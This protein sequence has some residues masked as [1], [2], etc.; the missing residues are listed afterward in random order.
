MYAMRFRR[1]ASVAVL[2]AATLISIPS[3]AIAGNPVM[4]NQY[5]ATIVGDGS[6]TP[7][8]GTSGDDVIVGSANNDVINGNGG[9]DIICG[10]GGRDTI[11]GG[12]GNDQIWGQGGHDQLRGG[13][14]ND[15][16]RGGNGNDKMRGKAG[17]N[18]TTWGGLGSDVC[19]AER[20]GNCELDHRWGHD[21]AEWAD[22]IDEYFGDIGESENALIIVECES[23]GEPFAVGGTGDNYYGLFQHD[24]NDWDRRAENAGFPDGSP[25]NPEVNV[26]AA[27]WYSDA[28]VEWKNDPS[29]RWEA[30]SC[31]REL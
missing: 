23:R 20:E 3:P 17:P 11:D 13:K 1:A 29:T 30:W 26:A 8:E 14:G 7:L 31:S 21:T 18:D 15:I 28:W 24:F 12:N 5:E 16:L 10:G 2:A 6:Q 9:H 4:C 27:R 19:I 22:L 25:F